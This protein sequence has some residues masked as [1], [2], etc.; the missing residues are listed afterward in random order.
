MEELKKDLL[1]F[2]FL[3]NQ[4]KVELWLTYKSIKPTSA[5]PLKDESEVNR[6]KLFAWFKNGDLFVN[7]DKD[8]DLYIVSKSLELIDELLPIVFSNSKEDIQKKCTLYGYPK[9]TALA[10]FRNFTQNKDGLP[11]GVG[12]KKDNP[13][14]ITWWPYV[15]YVV[16]EGFEYED[17]LAAKAWQEEIIKEFPGLDRLFID[18][19]LSVY[20]V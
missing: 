16:R 8:S 17:S 6:K 15:R 19:L 14:N 11:V 20:E 7:K 4:S 12:L 3:S 9:E 18:D 2:D 1:S 5:F 10:A 13:F